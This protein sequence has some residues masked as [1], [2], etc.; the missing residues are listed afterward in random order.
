MPTTGEQISKCRVSV[1]IRTEELARHRG[2]RGLQVLL[3]VVLAAALAAA[4]AQA[5]LESSVQP[6]SSV[7]L[8]AGQEQ[9]F[10]IAATAGGEQIEALS[11]L[12]GQELAV[13]GAAGEDQAISI[14]HSPAPAGSYLSA[15]LPQATAAVA[16]NGFAVTH[17]YTAE[18]HRGAHESG[19]PSRPIRGAALTLNFRTSEANQLVLALVGAQGGGSPRLTGIHAGA[20]QDATYDGGGWGAIACAAVYEA[21]LRAGKHKLGVSTTTYIPNSGSALGVVLYVLTP[22]EGR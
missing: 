17:V 6:G 13:N 14:G 4:P 7:E 16:L 15:A 10:Y 2:A 18:A 20:L 12:E 8:P 22:L 21:Q 9:Y 19:H 3:L 5:S 1:A 11:W